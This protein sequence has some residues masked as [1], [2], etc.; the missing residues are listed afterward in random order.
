EADARSNLE[1]AHA[2]LTKAQAESKSNEQESG[3]SND[4]RR[5]QEKSGSGEP[6][7]GG[8]EDSPKSIKAGPKLTQPT[9][10][11]AVPH[12][13]SQVKAGVSTDLQPI[14]DVDELVPM[15]PEATR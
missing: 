8:S 14:P 10:T 13:S 6:S 7:Q 9:E 3:N 1:L 15:S 5:S 2:L 4:T 11:Q 12:V